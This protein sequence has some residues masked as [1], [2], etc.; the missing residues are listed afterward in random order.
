[1][2]LVLQ[3]HLSSSPKKQNGKKNMSIK[4]RK[5]REIKTEIDRQR[6]RRRQAEAE[7]CLNCIQTLSVPHGW[8]DEEFDRQRQMLRILLIRGFMEY[9]LVSALSGQ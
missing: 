5:E 3:A 4:H 7:V 8:R 2:A 1:M 6:H 9:C